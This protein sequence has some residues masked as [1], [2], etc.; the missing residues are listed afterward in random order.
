[1]AFCI[2]KNFI[3]TPTRFPLVRKILHTDQHVFLSFEIFYAM[4]NA[5]SASSK[6]FTPCPSKF[7]LIL[8][9]LFTAQ[10]VFGL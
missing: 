9:F 6:I 8:K 1:M 4:P 5:L 7:Q 3:S 2:N 10:A